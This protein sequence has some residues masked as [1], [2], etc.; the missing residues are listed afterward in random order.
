MDFSPLG[1]ELQ[2]LFTQPIRST[3][4]RNH[5]RGRPLHG[6]DGDDVGEVVLEIL[7]HSPPSSETF[8]KDDDLV[9]NTFSG[10]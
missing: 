1:V 3:L 8:S 5:S 9:A 10:L 7:S 4:A 2:A 6:E